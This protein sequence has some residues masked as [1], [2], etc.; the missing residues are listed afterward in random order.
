M[1]VR[2]LAMLKRIP[3][4]PERIG[5]QKLRRELQDEGF[6]VTQ[7]TVQRDLKGLAEIFPGLATDENPDAAGWYWRKE[8]EVNDLPG[9]DPPTALSFKLV[10]QFLKDQIP[11]AVLGLL[12]RY[13]ECADRVL[14]RL[15]RPEMAKWTSKIK[16]LPRTQ[17]LIAAEIDSTVIDV[18]YE[19]LFNE[20]RFRGRYRRR[21][22]DEVEYDLNPLGLVFRESVV[23]LVATV[24]E[25]ENPRHF[26][27]HRFLHCESREQHAKKPPGFD[28]AAYISQGPF[29]YVDEETE[30]IRFEALF[31]ERTA[32]HLE[33]T[34]LS[35]DQ[36]TE[37]PE[38]GWVRVTATVKNTLQLRWWLLGFGD[39]VV[40]L[41]PTILR[42]ELLKTVKTMVRHYEDHHSPQSGDL[43]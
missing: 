19:A 34:P 17:P 6:E 38:N 9:I 27:L 25:Y 14:D 35:Y 33:E 39:Q 7:R 10:E 2:Y 23:Y 22:G 3:R 5:T 21:D 31:R 42:N 41:N 28:L 24:W 18:V 12:D 32:R 20:R 36:E 4:N 26:A 40:V 43:S 15:N 8:A 11:P 37:P 1:L 30:T 16:I 13:F 29:E